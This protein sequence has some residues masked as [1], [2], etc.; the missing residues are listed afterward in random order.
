MLAYH[1]GVEV[2]SR[3][4]KPFRRAITTMVSTPRE[5][6]FLWQRRGLRQTAR[7]E[8][9]ADGVRARS[10]GGGRRRPARQFRVDDQAVPC[11]AAAENGTVA[12]DLAA[13]GWTAADDILEAPLGFFQAAGGGFDPGSIVDR[14][15][16]P[17]TFASPGVSIKPYPSGSL[18]HPAM[19]EMLRLIRENK[20]KPRRRREGGRRRQPQ[21]DYHAATIIVPRRACRAS[22]AWSFAS[23][24]LILERKAGL[25]QFTDAVVQRPD[26]QEMIGRINFYVDPEAEAAGFDKMTS[27]LKSAS[28][29][30]ARCFPAARNLPRAARQIP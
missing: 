26:V 8:R 1:V 27:I 16:K 13:L 17:W 12:V 3:L 7:A 11:G 21:H 19:G 9:Q 23:S 18:T 10:R 30:T 5:H 14:L 22:S 24:I 4:P 20:I 15:G 6:R 25:S 2:E 29:R 28:E